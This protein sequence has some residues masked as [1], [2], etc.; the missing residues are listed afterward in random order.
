MNIFKSLKLAALSLLVCA[1]FTAC[2]DDEPTPTPAPALRGQRGFYVLCQGNQNQ[3]DGTMEFFSSTDEASRTSNLFYTAN[4]KSLG[5][6]PQRPVL[7]GSKLYIPMFTEKKVWVVDAQTMHVLAEV[8]KPNANAGDYTEG[9]Q[10]V[11]S[12]NGY[13]YIAYNDGT[14]TRMDTTAYQQSAPITVGP[15][16]ADIA[17]YDGKIYVSVSD[18]YNFANNYQNGLKV[19]QIDGASFEVA[20]QYTVGMNPGQLAIDNS[21]NVFVVCRGNYGNVPSKVWEISADGTIHEIGAGSII[22]INNQN[23]TS[24]A[25]G[26]SSVLYVL[27]VQTVYSSDYKSWTNTINSYK[28]NT[29]TRERIAEGF[30]DVNNLPI[31]PTG[32]MD[33][34]PSTGDLY[35]C[36]DAST[37]NNAYT[38]EGK[39]YIY[40][41]DGVFK[42]AITTGVHPY[43]VVFK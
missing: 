27:N 24:R 9:P 37:D 26:N 42:K 6:S 19:A 11:C 31:N 33:V 35:I 25:L 38:T 22:A 29:L 20:N 2:S 3:L 32:I 39:I 13:V 10:A 43:G 16:P 41:A 18:G 23:R 30:L 4:Q 5:D 28:Y 17:A 1:G 14:V 34:N 12:D 21:G 7:Y 15:N 8:S 40:S 36:S